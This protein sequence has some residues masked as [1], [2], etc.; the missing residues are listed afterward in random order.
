MFSS[1]K[2]STLGFGLVLQAYIEDTLAEWNEAA[3]TTIRTALESRETAR[4]INTNVSSN[5]RRPST[6]ASPSA[7]GRSLG[8]AYG[9]VDVATGR[10]GQS[11]FRRAASFARINSW[12][13]D[14]QGAEE[15][16]DERDAGAVQNRNK[17]A[18]G[19]LNGDGDEKVEVA[20]ADLVG[21]LADEP[22]E[23]RL[24]EALLVTSEQVIA[25]VGA[26][27]VSGYRE[28]VGGPSI[29]NRTF[30]C[31]SGYLSPIVASAVVYCHLHEVV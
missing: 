31:A 13:G 11:L 8:E 10:R 6:A 21:L 4:R 2:G 15:E 5:P 17:P 27:Q 22:Q 20:R 28:R 12:V 29:V 24:M 30:A 16:N 7:S 9:R 14:L 3:L 23:G 25:D 19:S 26:Q 18:C 1:L